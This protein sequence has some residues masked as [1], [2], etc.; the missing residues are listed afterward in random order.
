[1]Q[2]KCRRES[3]RHS[4]KVVTRVHGVVS[5]NVCQLTCDI[6]HTFLFA[7]PR[8]TRVTSFSRVTGSLPPTR[9]VAGAA[10]PPPPSTPS[11]WPVHAPRAL[12]CPKACCTTGKSCC[13]PL[14]RPQPPPPRNP[15]RARAP[16]AR[17]ACAQSRS[18]VKATTPRQEEG[19]APAGLYGPSPPL[20]PSCRA[21]D[22]S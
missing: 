4:L 10:A 9:F 13:C 6:A 22:P 12:L 11:I 21:C 15:A 14:G 1:M 5:D 16:A 17:G 19:P 7:V 2:T 20:R 3:R 8:A 18:R